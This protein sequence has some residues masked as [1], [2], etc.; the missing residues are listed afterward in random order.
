MSAG[1][2]VRV[3]RQCAFVFSVLAFRLGNLV[4]YQ[5]PRGSAR[6]GHLLPGALAMYSELIALADN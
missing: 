1:A 4:P 6:I 2:I 3:M 5:R